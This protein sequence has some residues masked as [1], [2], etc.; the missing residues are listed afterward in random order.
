M[1]SPHYEKYKELYKARAKKRREQPIYNT[2]LRMCERCSPGSQNKKYRL[3]R[4]RG[5]KVLFNG[6]QHFIQWSLENGWSEGLTIDRID[7]FGHYSPDNC[8]WITLEENSRRATAK[9]VM[10][11]DGIEYPSIKYASRANNVS[12]TAIR[13]AIKHNRKSAGYYWSYKS[14]V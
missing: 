14:T 13:E 5:I 3:Y 11:S 6:P 1:N 9:P 12:D 4:E 10:R 2:Y 7:P 8:R